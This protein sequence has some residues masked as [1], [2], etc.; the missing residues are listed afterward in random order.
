MPPT[1]AR[2]PEIPSAPV[3]AAGSYVRAGYPG[4]AGE[5][6]ACPNARTGDSQ[7]ARLNP[8]AADVDAGYVRHAGENPIPADVNARDSGDA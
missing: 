7:R 5:N 6:S 1:P 2:T 8:T 3:D 4:D